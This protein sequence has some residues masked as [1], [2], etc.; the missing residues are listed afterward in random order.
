MYRQMY[1]SGDGGGS[2]D[3]RCLASHSDHQQFASGPAVVLHQMLRC[4]LVLPPYNEEEKEMSGVLFPPSW[5]RTSMHHV[6]GYRK[7]SVA[8]ARHAESEATRNGGTTG[9]A[10]CGDGDDAHQRVPHGNT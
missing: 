8:V 1:S 10:G 2:G 6:V 5:M 9:A 7:Q 4:A 3:G